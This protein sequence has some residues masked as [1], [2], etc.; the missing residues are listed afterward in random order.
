[1]KFERKSLMTSL[2]NAYVIE[3]D[4]ENHRPLGHRKRD[5]AS[6]CMDVAH[7]LVGGHCGRIRNAISSDITREGRMLG[8]THRP[9][10]SEKYNHRCRVCLEKHKRGQPVK[11]SKT[12]FTCASPFC[13]GVYL[14]I[15]QSS[16]C[17]QDWHFKK[18][19]WH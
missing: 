2:Y 13:Q 17:W 11:P 10:C 16:T 18:Q 19:Y 12:C 6:F 5:F 3:G 9:I 7:Q 15:K 14:C 8:N 1:M 4:F